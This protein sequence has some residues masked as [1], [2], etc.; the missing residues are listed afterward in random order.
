MIGYDYAIL[1]AFFAGLF[2]IIPYFGPLIALILAIL[3]GIVSSLMSGADTQLLW[4]IVITIIGFESV[5]ILDNLVLQ[6]NIYAKSVKSTPFEVFL[7]LVIGEELFGIIG[8]ILSVPVYTLLRIIAVQ[9][10]QGVPLIQKITSDLEKSIE[11]INTT[12][13]LHFYDLILKNHK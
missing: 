5:K 6:P 7:V 4:N 10:L 3:L 11:K 13:H 8:M 2:N 1:I 9:T 12:S